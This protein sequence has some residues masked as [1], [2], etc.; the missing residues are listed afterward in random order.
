[1]VGIPVPLACGHIL[2]NQLYGVKSTDPLVLGGA[3]LLLAASA[4]LVDLPPHC[5][6]AASIPSRLCAPGD[7]GILG[8]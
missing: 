4:T 2:A 8:Q 7:R 6:P 5:A 1:M 3:A